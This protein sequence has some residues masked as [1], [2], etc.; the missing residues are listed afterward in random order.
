MSEAKNKTKLPV[1]KKEILQDYQLAV[2]SREASLI[3][4]KEVFMGK[5]KFG[6]FGDGKE[7]PQIAMAK[8][9]QNGDWRSGYYRDQ[10]FMMAIGQLTTQQFFAQLYAHTDV[11][12]DPASAGRMMNGHFATRYLNEKGEWL[13]QTDKKNSSADISPTAGQ[14][15]RLLGLAYASKLYRENKELSEFED[16]S[17]NGNEI[18]FGTIGNASTSEGHFW[19]TMN[20]AGVLQVPMIMSVWDDGYGISVPQKY[21]TIKE[22]ISEALSGFQQTKD[23]AGFEVIKV[24]AWD[25]VGLLEAYKKAVDISRKKHTPCLIHVI[26][27]TQPQGHS[28]SGSHERYKSKDR[29][30]WEKE[31]DCILKMREWI[32]S[33]KLAS[34]DELDQLEKEAKQSAKQ[35]KDQAWKDYITDIKKDVDE[36][37]SL[38]DKVAISSSKKAEIAKIA[39]SLRKELNP[40]KSHIIKGAKKTL[41]LLKGQ[42]SGEKQNLV[43]WLNE[44]SDV[45]EHQFSSKLYS[46]SADAAINVET[47]PASYNENSELVDGREVLNA[48][49]DHLLKTDARIFAFG[50][51][52]GKIG[53]VNQGFAGLQEKYGELKVTDTG[54]RETT[55]IGQ[56]IGA[57]VRG[58]R[59][60]AE[61]QY[62]DYLLYAIQTLSDDLATLQYRTFGGQKA[63][64]IIRTRGHRLEGVWHSGSPMGMI[65]HSLRGMYVLT[66]RN[67]TQA[68]GFYNTLMQSDDPALVIE[69]LNGYRLKERVPENLTE[70]KLALGE[71]EILREGSD[72]TV[73][74]YGSTCRVVMEAANQL[75]EEG[76]ELEVIDAQ[77]LIPFDRPKMIVDSLEKTNRLVVVDEDVE[78]GAS[79]FILQ[80]ILE[81]DNGYFNLDSKPLTITGKNH[82][83]AYGSDGDYFSK[84]NVEEIFDKV[85]AMISE[86]NPEEF[87]SIY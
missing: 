53:D 10:T 36:V 64:L 82:R 63:P 4:R 15:P 29:L 68:A 77:T 51:D 73:V 84:P 41:R 24:K 2:E 37:L 11:E 27:V 35:A 42:P 74:T 39:D 58:L 80:Q 1:S 54:I 79:A 71:P 57:A 47:I 60:I 78:G 13:T 25:Y 26:E 48:C 43:N 23:K 49:F 76:I 55:I 30:T 52:V 12:A 44:K 59:P 75:S 22:S 70:F 7:L 20:A 8:Y 6:I 81:R 19:E 65:L 9:F 62:L 85:Y 28:T 87:P 56:G 17:I 32:I 66:P 69:S 40:E 38:I 50:E 3:G 86:T 46:E 5:A 31:H 83:P 34:A 33:E 72:A 18:A 14:M 21:H 61:I 16:F 45:Y 67:M